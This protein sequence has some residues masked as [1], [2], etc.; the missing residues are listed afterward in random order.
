M[1]DFLGFIPHLKEGFCYLKF[2]PQQ[3]GSNTPLK[4]NI[5]IVYRLL[6]YHVDSLR[7]RF[8]Y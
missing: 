6:S 5:F 2:D 1:G 8:L 7:M 3:R 4:F